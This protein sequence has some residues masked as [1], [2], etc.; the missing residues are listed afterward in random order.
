MILMENKQEIRITAVTQTPYMVEDNGILYSETIL[1][2]QNPGEEFEAWVKTQETGQDPC[3]QSVGKIPHGEGEITV[4]VPD[5][6]EDGDLVTFELCRTQ[7]GGPEAS[8]SLPQKKVRRWK[9]YVSHSFHTDI[10]YTDYQEYLIRQK[11]PEHLDEALQFAKDTSG[12]EDADQFRHHIESSY[13]LYGSALRV[14]DAGWMETLKD[15]LKQDRIAYSASYMN[16]SMEVM[17]SEELVRYYYYSGRHLKDMLGADPSG[18]AMMVDNPSISWSGID[19]MANAGIK[20]M[21]LGPNFNWKTPRTVTDTYPRLFYMKGRNPE[22]KVLIL[23]G[24]LYNLDEMQFVDDGPK[25]ELVPL[26]TTVQCTANALMNRYHT[27]NYPYDAVVQMVDQYWDN[28]KLFPRVMERIREMN[29]RRDAKGRPY[30]YPKFINSNMKDFCAYIEEN[31]GPSIASYSGTFEN[32]WCYGTPSDAY[33]AALVREAHDQLPAAEALSAV[34]HCLAPG[35]PYPYQ[36]IADAYNDMMLYDEHTFGP[37]DSSMGEQHIWKRNTA[38]AAKRMSDELMDEAGSAL[39]RLIPT[40]RLT[41]A[42]YNPLSWNRNDAAKISLSGLP[43]HFDLVDTVTGKPVCYQK[44][45]EGFLEFWA[46][47]IPALGYKCYEV[48]ERQ[49]DPQFPSTLEKTENTLENRFYRVT[50]DERGAV[51]S[52]V[53]KENGGIELVDADAPY[54]M[55]EFVYMTSDPHAYPVRS[56][57]RVEEAERRTC[58]GPVCGKVVSSG[59]CQGTAGIRQEV[60]LYD[61]VP[62]IDFVNTVYKNDALAWNSQ[63]E[64]GFFVFPMNVP[65]FTL[66]HEMPSGDV[67]PYVDPRH[68]D[69]NQECPE[70]EQFYTSSTDFYTVNRWIDASSRSGN[71]GVTLSAISAPIVQYGE[72]RTLLYD[73]DYNTEKPWV[74]SYAINNKWGTNFM[75]TQPGVLTFRY[76]LRS[77]TGGDWRDGR[78]DHFGWEQSVPLFVQMLPGG[79]AGKLPEKQGQWLSIDA[80]NVVLTAAK[81]AEANGEGLILRFNETL[82]KETQ[83]S[84]DLSLFRPGSAVETDLMENDRKPAVLENGKVTFSID[85]YGWKTI[86]ICF[87]AEPPAVQGV[88]AVTGAEGTRV[89]W[90]DAGGSVGFYEVFRGSREDFIPGTGSY[91]GSTCRT[92]FLDTQV[93]S[94]TPSSWYYKVRSVQGGRKGKAS[95]AKEA[96]CG[97]QPGSRE[98]EAPSGLRADAA[99]GNRVSLSWSYPSDAPDLLGFRLY[100][101]G[102]QLA[103][104][105]PIHRSYLDLDVVPGSRETY[106]ILAYGRNGAVSAVSDPVT[107]EPA[108]GGKKPGNLAREARLLASSQLSPRFPVS[109]AADGLIGVTGQWVS[110]G[111]KT[112]WIRLEWEGPRTIDRIVLYDRDTGEGQ[113]RKGILRFSDGSTVE[114]GD[115]SDG[116]FGKTVTFPAKTVC[117]VTFQVTESKGVNVGLAEIEVYQSKQMK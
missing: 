34:A 2:V 91:L 84:V 26:E 77:H 78:A 67:K 55:N 104:L 111:E 69:P 89:C 38:I 98:L 50:F 113:I 93:N 86:R 106:W 3:W 83:A 68:A 71:Y 52:I 57:G 90:E 33:S 53:D 70:I 18:L 28:G 40:Q 114:V 36:K 45:E 17:S 75:R 100:R 16:S 43:A 103:D 109:A 4:D 63:N 24:T 13:L 80:D 102:E 20:Y 110:A 37:G 1:S 48:R 32:W 54:H 108:E 12:W 56:V 82:G 10:G 41:V 31:Y 88:S 35:Q 19:V 23:S 99:F 22:N 72:R 46:E 8:V 5:L 47:G 39:S 9:V 101:D 97:P 87:G 94:Q 29:H 6:Q 30:V 25:P 96:K 112:P 14:R 76:S 61:A 15:Y 49:D 116:A 66:R 59:S 62:R 81:I 105:S 58:C 11:W 7:G 44:T 107:A 85:G 74:Y 64:E 92:D 65:D 51:C 115:F 79:Q 95:A 117:W 27:E 42:V 73:V 21:Y 60:I